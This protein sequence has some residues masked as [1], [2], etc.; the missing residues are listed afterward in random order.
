MTAA[1][2]R[3]DPLVSMRGITKRFPGVT[4]NENVDLVLRPGEVHVLLGENGAGKSTLVGMLAGLQQPDAGTISIGGRSERIDSPG[5]ALAFGIGTV[6]QHSMLVPSLSVLDN[7]ALGGS[8]WRKP[9]RAGLVARLREMC[10]D[11]G[12]EVDPDVVVGSLSLG[13]R[14]QVE[15]LRAL[16]RGSQVLILD[17]ATAMLTPKGAEDL[18]VLMRRLVA[19]GLGVVLITHK[20]NEA[21]TYGDRISVLR[22]GRNVGEIGPTALASLDRKSATDEIVRLMFGV[23]SRSTTEEASDRRDAHAI[24]T[25]NPPPVSEEQPESPSPLWRGVRGEG[26]DALTDAFLCPPTQVFQP[27]PLTPLH[28]GEGNSFHASEI[29]AACSAALS[30]EHLSVDDPLMPLA[31][32]SLRVAPGEI[33]G[34]AGI[35]GNGQKQFAEALAGQRPVRAGTI[36]LDGHQVGQ[37]D[38][39]ARHAL[40]LRYVT[41][42]RLGEGTV[43]AFPLAINL[44]LKEI[45]ARPFWVGGWQRSA[46][47]DTHARK[48]VADFDI[49]TPDIQTPIGKLSGGNIQRALLARELEGPARVVIFAKPTSGLDAQNAQATRRRIRDAAASGVAALLISTDLEELLAVCDRIAVM[50]QGRIVGVVLN[51]GMARQCVGEMMSGA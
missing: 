51:D 44:V 8:W 10:R 42:D 31:D 24:N 7:L 6:F 32:I 28:K 49:R 36:R 12:I 50:R 25:S 14:Q 16:L 48:L 38:V 21:V 20:L 18:G 17:E 23:D 15:I 37:L 3:R 46:T 29:C 4:A 40:G 5:R 9:D 34:I 43:A 26:R 27:S 2:P 1:Q 39:A 33:L 22:L 13:E 47:I 35:D 11:I 41:D 30:V 19:R 45:G